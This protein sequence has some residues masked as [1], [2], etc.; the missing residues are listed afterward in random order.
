MYEKEIMLDYEKATTFFEEL[1]KNGLIQKRGNRLLSNK[2]KM[3]KALEV[4]SSI[5]QNSCAKYV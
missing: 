2:D 1:V 4:Y 3:V 5:N